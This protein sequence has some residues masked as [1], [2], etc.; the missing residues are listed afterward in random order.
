MI[1][2]VPRDL[3]EILEMIGEKKRVYIV[4][5]AGCATLCKTGG[6]EQTRELEA[7]L[8][9]RGKEVSGRVVLDVPCDERVARLELNKPEVL[10]SDVLVVM[11]CG[12]GVQGVRNCVDLPALPVLNSVF[13]GTVE[14]IGIYKEYCSICGECIIETMDSLCPITRC[15][16]GMVNGPCGG[17]VDGKCEVDPEMDCVWDTIYRILKEK[18]E[19][20]KLK[21][22]QAPKNH[23]KKYE[24]L[25]SFRKR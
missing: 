16:K 9:E 12:A 20:E 23:G 15:A 17:M 3:S 2:T 18:G 19:L 25:R 7:R 1:V 4:G 14:R 11:A 21:Q 22:Y 13:L 10:A 6:E 8:S 24:I 5:C